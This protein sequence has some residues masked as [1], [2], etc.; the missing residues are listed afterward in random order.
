M[1]FH[2]IDKICDDFERLW[3]RGD[4]PCIENF[5]ATVDE[6]NAELLVELMR[7]DL[8][9]AWKTYDPA[10][11]NAQPT[12]EERL[13]RFPMLRRRE[14]LIPLIVDEFRVRQKF[15]DAP[16]YPRFL[17]SYPEIAEELTPTLQQIAMELTRAKLIAYDKANNSFETAVDG[18]LEI[19]RQRSKEP[20][21][22]CRVKGQSSADR[23]VI[24]DRGE[25][26]I[27]RQHIQLEVVAM[28]RILITARSQ[29]AVTTVTGTGILKA[30]EQVTVSLPVLIRIGLQVVRIQGGN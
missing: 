7:V 30:G 21:P 24:A 27:G 23:I 20:A 22:M 15:G 4:R 8:H 25:N 12:L 5:V 2:Q 1:Q 29:E 28:N 3:A 14:R 19:G 16:D 26:T 9:Y 13:C 18:P 10:G 11:G 6:S 17:L